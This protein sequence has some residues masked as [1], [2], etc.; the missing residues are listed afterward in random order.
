MKRRQRPSLLC[1]VITDVHV[2]QRPVELLALTVE[3]A[4]WWLAAQKGDRRWKPEVG[5]G[6]SGDAVKTSQVGVDGWAGLH[7]RQGLSTVGVGG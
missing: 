2:K 7:L 4:K 1:F 6:G 5:G 3:E